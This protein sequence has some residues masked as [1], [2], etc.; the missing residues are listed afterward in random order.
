MYVYIYICMYIE[1][2]YTYKYTQYTYYIIS[3]EYIYISSTTPRAGI[4]APTVPGH[5]SCLAP[6]WFQRRQTWQ[7]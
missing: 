4:E 5:G 7:R 1:S 6:L 3:Y 2:G